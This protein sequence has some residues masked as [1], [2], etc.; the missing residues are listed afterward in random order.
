MLS[1]ETRKRGERMNNKNKNGGYLIPAPVSILTA[2]V[3]NWAL[4][5]WL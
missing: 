5:G 1:K 3:T 2:L 4:K